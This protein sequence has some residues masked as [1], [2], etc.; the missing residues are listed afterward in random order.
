MRVIESRISSSYTRFHKRI[1]PV[2]WLGIIFIIL[3]QIWF[4]NQLTPLVLLIAFCMMLLGYFIMKKT[5]W[6]LADEVR[7]YGN[8]LLVSKGGI[9][10]KIMLSNILTMTESAS[11]NPSRITLVL[12]RRGVLGKQIAFAPIRP[13]SWNPLAK[14]RIGRDLAERIAVAQ[15]KQVTSENEGGKAFPFLK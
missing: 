8:F 2:F 6:D 5:L 13:F 7:D 15:Q 9:E 1:F 12:A 4:K 10:E 11:L 14:S 3:I